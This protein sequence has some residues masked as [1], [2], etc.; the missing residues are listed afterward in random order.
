MDC[1]TMHAAATASSG[2]QNVC[3]SFLELMWQESPNR[4]DTP[5]TESSTARKAIGIDQPAACDERK[6]LRPGTICQQI[7]R[8]NDS[9]RKKTFF[10]DVS[11]P[12]PTPL[13]QM[14]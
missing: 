6:N 7:C 9:V 5:V 4:N 1:V 13:V 2:P 10:T 3:K 11:F 12:C 8:C 14:S